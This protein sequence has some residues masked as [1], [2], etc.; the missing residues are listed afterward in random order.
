MPEN[1]CKREYN[2]M[3]LERRPNVK[4]M[5][6]IDDGDDIGLLERRKPL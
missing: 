5:R 1:C 6:C 3:K 4:S 2:P